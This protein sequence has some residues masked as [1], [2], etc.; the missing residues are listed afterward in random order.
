MK[1]K[2]VRC[3]RAYHFQRTNTKNYLC[4]GRKREE[5]KWEKFFHY[6]VIQ[7]IHS[8][9]S[10][11]RPFSNI[12]LSVTGMDFNGSATAPVII[13]LTRFMNALGVIVSDDMT[14]TT[15]CEIIVSI[16]SLLSSLILSPHFHHH[17]DD[18]LHSS[19][20]ITRFFLII[21]FIFIFPLDKFHI[22]NANCSIS[23]WWTSNF[24]VLYLVIMCSITEAMDLSAEINDAMW[25][26]LK[27]VE[28]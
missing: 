3:Q 28:I 12:A 8:A 23:M 25:G 11:I 26:R 7:T 9:Q 24:T 18:P 6:H 4:E 2:F 20:T 22:K 16:T 15:S 5:V 14:S 1:S 10:S 21:I 17:F 13:T 27:C 19:H